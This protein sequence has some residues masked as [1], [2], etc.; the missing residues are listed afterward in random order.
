[1]KKKVG[2]KLCLSGN[3]DTKYILVDASKTEVEHAVKDAI[4]AMGHGGGFLIS[5]ANFHP[6]MSPKRLK[7]MIDAANK[8]GVYPL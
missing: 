8:F 3:I 7:W 1:V 2:D 5:P 4:S 6:A